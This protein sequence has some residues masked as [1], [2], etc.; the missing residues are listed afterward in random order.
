[1]IRGVAQLYKVQYRR[2][3][4]QAPLNIADEID[5]VAQERAPIG[6]SQ[7]IVEF[8]QRGMFG[9]GIWS[10]EQISQW[11]SDELKLMRAA[12]MAI[13]ALHGPAE[14][15]EQRLGELARFV[16]ESGLRQKPGAQE[17]QH[18]PEKNLRA[19]EPRPAQDGGAPPGVTRAAGAGPRHRVSRS[20]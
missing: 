19:A 7:I 20:A 2:Y 1:M 5:R 17:Y 3:G 11:Q 9:S 4:V 12:R 6:A 8:L 15:K 10:A 16:I 13:D 14:E 18:E